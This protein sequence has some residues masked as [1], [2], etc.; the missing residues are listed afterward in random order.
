MET[1]KIGDKVKPANNGED[2]YGRIIRWD[3]LQGTVVEAWE[4]DIDG[5]KVRVRWNRKSPYPW[6]LPADWL[7]KV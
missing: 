3:R 5:Q 2:Q 1:L 7:V 4:D 6:I